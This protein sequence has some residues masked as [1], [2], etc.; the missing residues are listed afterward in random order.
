MRCYIEV[1]RSV[2]FFLF[3]ILLFA[4]PK[5]KNLGWVKEVK[6]TKS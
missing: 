3:S 5:K 2:W 6:T 1:L 4:A